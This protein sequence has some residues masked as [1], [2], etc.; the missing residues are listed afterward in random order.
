MAETSETLLTTGLKNDYCTAKVLSA[1]LIVLF[2]K[3]EE[4]FC[5]FPEGLVSKYF[6][7]KFKYNYVKNNFM[8][9]H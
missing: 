4:R 5:L 7:N 1:T 8:P 9:F 3:K 6:F 2:K